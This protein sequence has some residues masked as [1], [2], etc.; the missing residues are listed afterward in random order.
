MKP[1]LMSLQGLK[2]KKKSR[3]TVNKATGR[4]AG[5]KISVSGGRRGRQPPRR[6]P[7]ACGRCVD[8]TPRA[9]QGF[10]RSTRRGTS[11]HLEQHLHLADLASV[12]PL[13]LESVFKKLESYTRKKFRN[14]S[15][16]SSQNWTSTTPYSEKKWREGEEKKNKKFITTKK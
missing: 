12:R 16:T 15:R 10:C 4:E 13:P 3:G 7:G 11:P 8:A 1:L 5:T 2:S 9:S 14:N 6:P